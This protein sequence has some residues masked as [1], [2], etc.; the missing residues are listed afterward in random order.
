MDL[1]KK[2]LPNFVFLV[3]LF[4]LFRRGILTSQDYL[5]FFKG[6]P[7]N[8]EIATLLVN[9]AKKSGLSQLYNNKFISQVIDCNSKNSRLVLNNE[10][11]L[12]FL[13]DVSSE[14]TFSKVVINKKLP[15]LTPTSD[16]DYFVRFLIEMYQRVTNVH[17]TKYMHISELWEAH[18]DFLED[19]IKIYNQI[20]P[21]VKATN[22]TNT[23]ND[24][25]SFFQE[26]FPDQQ[27]F[28]EFIASCQNNLH[29]IGNI[30]PPVT[31]MHRLS[32][33][34]EQAGQ[35]QS[36]NLEED[37]DDRILRDLLS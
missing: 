1:Q 10:K 7:V 31:T 12:K 15:T 18:K 6:L 22:T 19:E 13:S 17:T 9:S 20:F 30:A 3:K 8:P 32:L 23:T 27:T 35:N 11:L 2:D 16:S 14:R 4:C 24:T 25:D 26:L 37:D 33:F 36:S 34:T 29:T 21:P 5:E 28:D